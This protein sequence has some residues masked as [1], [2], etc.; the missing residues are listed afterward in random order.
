MIF[1]LSYSGGCDA[2]QRLKDGWKGLYP[3]S[4]GFGLGPL[5]FVLRSW[6]FSGNLNETKTKGRRQSPIPQLAFNLGRQIN[7][8]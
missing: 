2:M 1:T 3:G 4:L 8:C 7:Y 5:V 6:S